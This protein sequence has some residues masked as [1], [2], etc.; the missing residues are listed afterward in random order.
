[1]EVLPI[2]TPPKASSLLLSPSEQYEQ[3]LAKAARFLGVSLPDAAAATER[4]ARARDERHDA[5]ADSAR[6]LAAYLASRDGRS[7]DMG[8]EDRVL[9]RLGLSTTE[10]LDT[11][12][13]SPSLTPASSSLPRS[14]RSPKAVKIL[15]ITPQAEK[16]KQVLGMSD[17]EWTRREEAAAFTPPP[18]HLTHDP[19]TAP[20]KAQRL[21][22]FSPSVNKA[23][24]KLG[25]SK[26]EAE[27]ATA[28]AAVRGEERAAWVATQRGERQR[29]TAAKAMSL[30]GRNDLSAEKANRILGRVGG[31]PELIVPQSVSLSLSLSLSLA[32]AIAG[33]LLLLSLSLL[34]SSSRRFVY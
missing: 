11:V 15:G 3:R 9:R 8:G 13:P 34:L 31:E 6:L 29:W 4:A 7:V 21:L 19:H 12:A 16:A 1:M 2:Q 23:A 25:L 18:P 20:L 5:D 22:S 17:A 10:V 14:L 24:K 32:S 27:R 28:A 30:L 33:L 26:R